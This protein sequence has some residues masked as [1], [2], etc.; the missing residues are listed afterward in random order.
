VISD[1][2]DSLDALIERTRSA[3]ASG[4][5][6]GPGPF[7]G[8][9]DEGRVRAQVSPDGRLVSLVLDPDLQSR[10]LPALG[11]SVVAA[12]NAALDARPGRAPDSAALL[13][14]LREI[15]EESV[16]EMRRI[17]QSLTSALAETVA[18]VG[19]GSPGGAD[20]PRQL[21]RR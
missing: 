15:Q 18:R 5:E 10:A 9:A 8:E 17:T 4:Q 19:P 13:V 3:F 11:A 6:G 7:A 2:G 20:D 16:V 12:V 21:G 1:P 14:N